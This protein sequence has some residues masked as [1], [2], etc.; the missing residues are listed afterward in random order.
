MR[1]FFC[2]VLILFV[3]KLQAQNIDIKIL[4]RINL[5][6]NRDLDQTFQLFSN[7]VNAVTITTPLIV[8]SAGLIGKNKDI[9]SKGMVMIQSILVSTIISKPMKYIISRERPFVT[10]PEL[11]KLSD[12][13]SPSFPSGHTEAAFATATSLSLAFPK[14]YVI[15]PSY[16][17]AGAVGYSR[18]HLGVHYPSDVLAGAIIGSA[19]SYMTY[20]ANKWLQ[21]RKKKNIDNSDFKR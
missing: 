11:E 16:I 8:Y 1:L 17:W 10:Y 20:R 13:G 15:A 3:F 18:M 19:S 7:S 4:E 2:F 6:R 14:W 9:K 5:S 12:G 21:G